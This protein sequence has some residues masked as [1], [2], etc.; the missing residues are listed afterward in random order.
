M[1]WRLNLAQ[2]GVASGHVRTAYRTDDRQA[3]NSA[4]ELIQDVMTRATPGH[5]DYPTCFF[6]L[7]NALR[8]R[9]ERSGDR[10]DL[11]RAVTV[12]ETAVRALPADPG[13]LSNLACAYMNR[14]E[15]E[16]SF[17]DSDRAVEA[18]TRA[19][20][21]PRLR[22]ADRV[23]VKSNLAATFRRRYLRT[24]DARELEAAIAIGS[25]ALTDPAL[26]SA[27]RGAVL[28]TLGDAFRI[29]AER[30]SSEDDLAKAI[31][32]ARDAVGAT[33]PHHM[34]R[35]LRLNN[36]TVALRLQAARTGDKND[37]EQALSA[38]RDAVNACQRDQPAYALYQS[39]LGTVWRMRFEVSGRQGDL[40][41]AIAC[42]RDAAA[43]ELASPM[44]RAVAA[45]GWGTAAA[46]G[47]RWSEAIEGFSTAVGL[48]TKVAPRSLT[49]SD[50][51]HQL[52]NVSGL[53]ADA[54]ASCVRAGQPARAV[55][56]FE[57][58]RGVLLGQAL[59]ARTDMVALQAVHEDLAG[60]FTRLIH[61]LERGGL[62]RQD[63]ASAQPDP[64]DPPDQ[65]GSSGQ[66]DLLVNGQREASEALDQVIAR[67]RQQPGFEQFLMPPT[68]SELSPAAVDG[69]I[70]M[71]NVSRFGSFA[72]IVRADGVDEPVPL[73]ALSPESV[74]EQVRAFLAALEEA[75][76]DIR[77]ERFEGTLG[78]LWDAVAGPVF[79]RLAISGPPA[80]GEPWP[81]LWWCPS[82]LLSLLP[83]HAAGPRE[84]GAQDH[85][86][87][88]V[89]R[90]I[91]SYTPTVR[92]LLYARRTCHDVSGP[93][94]R[95]ADGP[96][97]I[98]AVAM[99]TTPGQRNLSEAD[100][101]VGG[102]HDRF[103]GQVTILAGPAATYEAVVS[104]LPS[105]R[106]AHFA[107]HGSSDL[108]SPSDST[109]LLYD[110]RQRPLAVPDIAK[111]DLTD[112]ELAFLSA[113]STAR[114]SGRL[115]D[116]AI[117]LVSAFQLAGYRQVIG[118]LWAI[119]DP[120]ARQIADE[121]YAALARGESAAA[122]LHDVT[123]RMSREWFDRPSEWASHVHVGA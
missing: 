103:P 92:A 87:P 105:A 71:L 61:Q 42:S 65:P 5:E 10:T 120:R 80:E 57:Q 21:A 56:L 76:V 62:P 111:L 69:S 106:W 63:Q 97:P 115:A 31:T 121:T 14:F 23:S 59:D 110:Y 81:R 44:V 45:Y 30:M 114:I 2:L 116:E 22:P 40:D 41:E 38:A 73:P 43:S 112:A 53:G 107:C 83:L 101:E 102:L 17:G 49:R 100:D 67:I 96:R 37:I 19:L 8:L 28:S 24:R 54:A 16:G 108:A 15:L 33:K 39:N 18:F 11:D 93:Q 123:R 12:G 60:Q 75:S 1:G 88:V 51:E 68:L 79:A 32:L 90:V 118:T 94:A 7:N 86:A 70:V 50:Q 99:P 95:M 3:L 58:G 35:A 29:R 82:G 84:T 91:S 66:A 104:A 20:A 85:P 64:P 25:Q 74:L 47:E 26:R 72:L 109:L 4:I 36:L 52:D 48:M 6:L 34:Q 98:V 117:H 113:C 55:E 78:W 46:V 13:L 77:E 119:D 89:D 9:Y 27:D 122:A